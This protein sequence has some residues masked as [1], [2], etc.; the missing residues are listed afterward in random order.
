MAYERPQPPQ[1]VFSQASGPY[2]RI[3]KPRNHLDLTSRIEAFLSSNTPTPTTELM[4]AA[5][6]PAKLTRISLHPNPKLQTQFQAVSGQA[7]H[8]PCSIGRCGKRRSGS[9]PARIIF[10]YLHNKHRVWG[11]R[12]ELPTFRF[13]YNPNES[14]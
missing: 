7:K 8:P 1:L 5:V 6:V 12:K 14:L 4:F 2:W 11:S 13:P 10:P 3:Q 9:A